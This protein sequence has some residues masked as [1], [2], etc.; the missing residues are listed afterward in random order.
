MR[1]RWIAVLLVVALVG[2]ASGCGGSDDETE[3]DPTVAWASGFCTAV[4][5]WREEL[6]T[7]TSQFSD[8]SNLSQEG[9]QSAA[10]DAKSATQHFLDELDDLG[11][12]ETASGDAVESSIDSLA[13]TLETE[14]ET[15]EATAND[16]SGLTD[17]PSA[18]STISASLGTLGT[19]LSEMLQTIENADV[20][21]ELES[22]LEDS[23]ECDD[24]ES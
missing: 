9:L 15:I 21:D 13:T 3:T 1:R 24:L 14:V 16:V 7:I 17:L 20:G 19:A 6:Q 11:A 23:P 2:V 22:A 8:T 12:P 4:S 18:I 10:T 5:N